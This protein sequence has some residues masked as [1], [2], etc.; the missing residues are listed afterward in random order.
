MY[1]GWIPS[2]TLLVTFYIP[3]TIS[4]QG[5]DIL[6][7]FIYLNIIPSLRRV[8]LQVLEAVPLSVVVH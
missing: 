2:M 8:R 5:C 6:T 1:S 3:V 4:T 7:M